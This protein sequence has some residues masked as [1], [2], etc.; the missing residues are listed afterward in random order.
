M[1]P[2]K[3][4]DFASKSLDVLSRRV[5][6]LESMS[7]PHAEFGG[8][9]GKGGGEMDGR[10]RALESGM[11]DV[12]VAL[13]KIET[14]LDFIERN[15]ITKGQLAI[16]ALLTVLSIAAGGWWIVQQYLAPILRAIPK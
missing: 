16:Y 10:I 11:T 15:M 3:I 8:G 14:R 2:I 13:G 5:D 4:P 9:G 12:K 1:D 6:K 7:Q